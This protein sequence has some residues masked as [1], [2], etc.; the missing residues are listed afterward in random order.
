M[1]DSAHLDV[2]RSVSDRARALLSVMTLREKCH[3]LTGVMAWTLTQPDGTDPKG[4]TKVLQHPPG[5]VA[6]LI[7]DDPAQLARTVT[8]IQRTL[9]SS[10]PGSAFPDCSMR[11]R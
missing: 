2:R 3:Q 4:L 7:L 1:T 5:H 8:A 10:A 9:S 6:H 11:R